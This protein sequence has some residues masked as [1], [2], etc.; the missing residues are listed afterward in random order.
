MLK[1]VWSSRKS[2]CTLLIVL[3]LCLTIV[4]ADEPSQPKQKLV[5]MF[6]ISGDSYSAVKQKCSSSV[7]F[8]KEPLKSQVSEGKFEESLRSFES[9]LSKIN[10]DICLIVLKVEKTSLTSFLNATTVS[11]DI[12]LELYTVAHFEINGAKDTIVVDLNNPNNLVKELLKSAT[13]LKY[14]KA[15][16]ELKPLIESGRSVLLYVGIEEE[17]ES[18]RTYLEAILQ[19]EDYYHAITHEAEFIKKY[20]ENEGARKFAVVLHKKGVKDDKVL[21]TKFTVDDLIKFARESANPNTVLT[22]DRED[23]PSAVLGGEVPCVFLLGHHNNSPTYKMFEQAAKKLTNEMRFV[24]ADPDWST[25]QRLINFLKIKEKDLGTGLWI[26]KAKWG[27]VF[28][29]KYP[30]EEITVENIHQFIDDYDHDKL[31]LYYHSEDAPAE[32]NDAVK[33]AVGNTFKDLVLENDINVMVDFYSIYCG[34][35]V[36]FAPVYEELGKLL[37]GNEKIRLVKIEMS[38]N[39]VPN[40]FVAQFPTIKLYKAKSKN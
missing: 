22:F 15:E 3:L 34:H 5:Q 9:L 35:C 6:H 2:Y 21:K 31:P 20:V 14:I 40:E 29:T 1:K 33:V 25:T 10:I 12:D 4:V 16:E 19:I 13:Q 23:S 27:W 7:T 28:K 18:L 17:K 8:E 37:K 11:K 30:Y 26:L 24:F 32:N 38:Q 36:T 39:E